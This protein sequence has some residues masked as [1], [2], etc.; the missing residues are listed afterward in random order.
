MAHIFNSQHLLSV[1]ANYSPLD[2]LQ[3]AKTRLEP[4]LRKER[5]KTQSSENL[6]RDILNVT[7]GRISTPKRLQQWQ[8]L[9][10]VSN[11]FQDLAA[12]FVGHF[13]HRGRFG[14]PPCVLLQEAQ[15]TT[16]FADFHCRLGN[17]LRRWGR[18]LGR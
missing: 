13:S 16:S 6:N 1:N 12:N 2:G 15:K 18:W 5:N 14:A 7:F 9:T 8:T 3:T 17:G 10:K 11:L 4:T